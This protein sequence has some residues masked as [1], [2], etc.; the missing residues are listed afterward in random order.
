[1]IMYCKVIFYSHD[2]RLTFIVCRYQ[3][4]LIFITKLRHLSGMTPK[5]KLLKKTLLKKTLDNPSEQAYKLAKSNL[6]SGGLALFVLSR[7]V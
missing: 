6:P 3:N 2:L 4:E 7:K 5:T 1:M